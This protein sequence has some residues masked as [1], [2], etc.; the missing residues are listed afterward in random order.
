MK[1]VFLGFI[2][3]YSTLLSVTWA[4]PN[5]TLNK[6]F[7][8]HQQTNKE[9]QSK[10]ELSRVSSKA[11]DTSYFESQGLPF[12]SNIPFPNNDMGA[13]THTAYQAARPKANF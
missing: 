1:K 10:K 3:I 8:D 11:F 7:Q 9:T 6:K 4:A 5:L 12:Q 2:A 13:K